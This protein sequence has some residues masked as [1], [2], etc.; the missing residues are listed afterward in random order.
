VGTVT[1]AITDYGNQLLD[2]TFLATAHHHRTPPI[3]SGRS[4]PTTRPDPPRA[5][6]IG[7][8]FDEAAEAGEGFGVPPGE[9]RV[10]DRVVE[11]PRTGPTGVPTILT[12]V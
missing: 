12:R 9:D 3:P 8:S 7:G 1:R 10:G 4:Q 5:R 11:L 6:A 2:E